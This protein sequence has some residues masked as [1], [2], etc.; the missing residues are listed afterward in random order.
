MRRTG[1]YGYLN[2]LSAHP[3]SKGAGLLYIGFEAIM[4][5]HYDYE[6]SYSPILLQ[7]QSVNTHLIRQIKHHRHQH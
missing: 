2:I 7:P 3:G 4:G 1:R 5:D 6:V